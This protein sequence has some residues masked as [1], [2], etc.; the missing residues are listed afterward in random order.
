MELA[1]NNVLTIRLFTFLILFSFLTQPVIAQ[2]GRNKTTSE[3]KKSQRQETK[4]KNSTIE[5]KESLENEDNQNDA[6]QVQ[7]TDEDVVKVDTNLILIPVIASDRNNIYTTDLKKEEFEIF[8]DN[9]KQEIVFFGTVS[10]PFHVVLMLDTSASTQEKL[11]LIQ[12]AAFT[13]VSQLQSGDKVKIISFDDEVKNLSEFTSDRNE[14]RNAIYR[15]RPGQGTKLYDAM[16]TA[17]ASLWRIQGR[18]AIVIFTDGVDWHSDYSN[19]NKNFNKLEESGIIVYPIRYDTREDVER[20]VRLQQQAGQ[21]VDLNVIFGTGVP[22]SGTPKTFP[23]GGG[24]PT[25]KTPPSTIPTT[26]IPSP[27]IVIN[28]PTTTTT[29]TSP[30]RRPTSTTGT[31][32]TIEIELDLAYNRADFYLKELANKTGGKLE[33]ADTLRDLPNAFAKIADELRTQYS[34]GYY[35]SNK[36]KDGRF[37][38][39]KVITTRKNV[40]IRAKPGY[41]VP[42]EV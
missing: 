1:M 26:T 35:S 34:I 30:G 20:L 17:I 22:T 9:V 31:K 25:T 21:V 7:L 37:R 10:Q 8:E 11:S 36:T 2:S 41:K 18:K 27:P 3:S 16:E 32:D 12:H 19:E 28:R 29:T 24:I 6:K 39:L 14:L 15:T 5:T 38:K 40:V 23:G 13:F 4:D 33:R 42:K